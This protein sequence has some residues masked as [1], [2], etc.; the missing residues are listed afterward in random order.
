MTKEFGCDDPRKMP[1]FL[2]PRCMEID[3]NTAIKANIR[4]QNCSI[5]PRY[6]YVDMSI[7]CKE[8]RNKFVFDT[9]EQRTWYE[10]YRFWIESI[11]TRCKACRKSVREE[12]SLRK[13]Y[14][15]KISIAISGHDLNQKKRSS[16]GN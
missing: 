15:A 1:D 10:Q 3:F 12:K 14:D 16:R 11:P 9:F 4:K 5:C 6:W 7:K 8:C 13:S 2:F